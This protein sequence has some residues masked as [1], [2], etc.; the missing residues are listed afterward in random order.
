MTASAQTASTERPTFWGR[1][2]RPFVFYVVPILVAL[3]VVGAI[4]L[5]A[6]S[7][8]PRLRVSPGYSLVD[9]NGQAVTSEDMRGGVVLYSLASTDCSGECRESLKVL[10]A[11]QE[12]LESS[13]LLDDVGDELDITFVTIF[14][15]ASRDTPGRLRDFAANQQVGGAIDWSLLTG[16]ASKLNALLQGGFGLAQNSDAGDGFTPAFFLVD[17]AGFVRAE[18]LQELPESREV[19]DDIASVVDEARA[20]GFGAAAYGAAHKFTFTCNAR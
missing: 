20:G 12:R 18:Y 9:Q 5:S 13:G 7:V 4:S 17:G 19:A 14:T 10:D 2:F 8:L 6:Y 16:D 15:D 11:V 3:V 1:W